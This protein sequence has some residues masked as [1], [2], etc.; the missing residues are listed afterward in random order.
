[1]L[2][3]LREAV[4]TRHPMHIVVP[5][6]L[7]LTIDDIEELLA[8]STAARDARVPKDVLANEKCIVCFQGA[9]YRMCSACV[10]WA[11]CGTCYTALEGRCQQCAWTTQDA[12]CAERMALRTK[13][14]KSELSAVGSPQPK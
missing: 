5:R 12:V 9:R 6:E 4:K 2:N 3:E 14:F 7:K 1:M 8:L 13:V 10:A 11:M